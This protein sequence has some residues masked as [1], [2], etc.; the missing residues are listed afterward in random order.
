MPRHQV[1]VLC[2]WWG[3]CVAPHPY[4]RVREVHSCARFGC[5]THPDQ[6]TVLAALHPGTARMFFYFY[7]CTATHMHTHTPP[8]QYHVLLVVLA[9]LSSA[10]RTHSIQSQG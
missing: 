5:S 2:A 10:V 8:C 9:I 3:W 7:I 6:V 4:Q 1:N